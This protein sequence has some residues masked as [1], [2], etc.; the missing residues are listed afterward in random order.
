M[1]APLLAR[2]VTRGFA[3]HWRLWRGLSPTLVPR[4]PSQGATTNEFSSLRAIQHMSVGR[5]QHVC[6]QT[7][8]QTR[9]SPRT[10]IALVPIH[11]LIHRPLLLHSEHEGRRPHVIR[12]VSST[13]NVQDCFLS[14]GFPVCGFPVK[15]WRMR[16][17]A[18]KFSGSGTAI[19]PARKRIT[20]IC[21]LRSRVG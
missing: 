14:A 3:G 20:G 2:G 8:A 13:D 11:I 17:K 12:R 1:W 16:S 9:A 15:T 5:R 18:L 4:S 10:Q 7:C 21:S 19:S 6:A